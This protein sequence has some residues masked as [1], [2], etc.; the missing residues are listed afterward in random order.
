MRRS[1]DARILRGQKLTVTNAFEAVGAVERKRWMMKRGRKLNFI[2]V[3]CGSCAGMFTANSMNCMTEV[4]GLGL[5]GTELFAV[6]AARIRLAKEAGMKVME[7]LE[8]DIRPRDIVQLILYTRLNSRYG[9]D[10]QQ[11]QYCICLQ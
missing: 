3:R 5:P 11:I 2:P 4:V 6:H 10:A 9:T 7:L 8:K 1:Y